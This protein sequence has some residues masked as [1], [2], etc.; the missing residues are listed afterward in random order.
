[1]FDELERMEAIE[2]KLEEA[3]RHFEKGIKCLD[4]ALDNS[5]QRVN[6][7]NVLVDQMAD[8]HIDQQMQQENQRVTYEQTML[9]GLNSALS[10][11]NTGNRGT[12]ENG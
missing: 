1:M 9:N 2:Q 8:D 12:E 3:R 7:L 11:I 6:E 5:L 10:I 4:E